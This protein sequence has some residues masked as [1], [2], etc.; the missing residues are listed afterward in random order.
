MAQATAPILDSTNICRDVAE[1]RSAASC[2]LRTRGKRA[3]FSLHISTAME[4]THDHSTRLL[5]LTSNSR[6]TAKRS[7]RSFISASNGWIAS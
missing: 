3:R 1:P 4:P 6:T 7:V 2:E 5:Q